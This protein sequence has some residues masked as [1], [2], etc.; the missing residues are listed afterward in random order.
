MGYSVFLGK[1][2]AHKRFPWVSKK[3]QKTPFCYVCNVHIHTLPC[4]CAQGRV[5][6][7]FSEGM[8]GVELDYTLG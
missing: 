3:K 4:K 8:V 7:Y 6:V 1:F 2:L 5:F